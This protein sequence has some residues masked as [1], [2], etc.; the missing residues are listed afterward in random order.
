VQES[1][2]P[3]AKSFGRFDQQSNNA[4]EYKSKLGFKI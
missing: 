2:E 1:M 3:N 4:D